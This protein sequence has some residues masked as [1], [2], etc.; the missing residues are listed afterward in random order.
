MSLAEKKSNS[1]QEEERLDLALEMADRTRRTLG[2]AGK[3]CQARIQDS[4]ENMVKDTI[5]AVNSKNHKDHFHFFE[6]FDSRSEWLSVGDFSLRGKSANSNEALFDVSN[7][8][9][10][11]VKERLG[12]KITELGKARV[13]IKQV[14]NNT[15]YNRLEFVDARAVAWEYVNLEDKL[16]SEGLTFPGSEDIRMTSPMGRLAW[17]LTGKN[18]YKE[19]Y[20][21]L[22]HY[23]DVT[24]HIHEFDH[25]SIKE[26]KDL[27]SVSRNIST[28]LSEA[29]EMVK[30]LSEKVEEN[31]GI[32]KI[33]DD[34]L[35]SLNH[36]YLHPLTEEHLTQI[37]SQSIDLLISIS[38]HPGI[39]FNETQFRRT[40]AK[41]QAAKHLSKKLLDIKE[42]IKA[43]G[44]QFESSFQMVSESE[45]TN[46]DEDFLTYFSAKMEIFEKAIKLCKLSA[47]LLHR[48]RDDEA[49]GS[50]LKSVSDYLIKSSILDECGQVR[51]LVLKDLL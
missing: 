43:L 51:N 49:M 20:D 45:L 2:I 13:T 25:S 42:E 46:D 17:S 48:S 18:H 36:N 6:S 44:D 7:V 40:I 19:L 41:Y 22:R 37:L 11:K 33:H 14:T 10:L 50:T 32:I 30:L 28:Q 23:D 4:I 16:T 35:L 3:N 5:R 9:I 26:P 8:N 34:I 21:K 1:R 15:G 47:P 39:V 38:R 29:R 24:R 31:E 27:I 12:K